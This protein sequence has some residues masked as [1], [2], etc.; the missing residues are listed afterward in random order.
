MPFWLLAVASV[1]ATSLL[2]DRI[3]LAHAIR[4]EQHLLATDREAASLGPNYEKTWKQLAADVYRLSS[5]DP[6][7]IDLLKR[8]EIHVQVSPP[9]PS[10]PQAPTV[11]GTS[12]ASVSVPQSQGR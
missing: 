7:L 11:S 8:H 4:D 2:I 5:R 6:A 12:P 3:F 10:L 1:V 9:A